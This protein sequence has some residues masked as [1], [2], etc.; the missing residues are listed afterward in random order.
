[1]PVE[2]PSEE[3]IYATGRVARFAGEMDFG[4]G[5]RGTHVGPTYRVSWNE[6]TH[7]LWAVSSPSGR[8]ILLGSIP[9][10]AEAE[11][12]L[13]GWQSWCGDRAPFGDENGLD[14]LV[15][16]LSGAGRLMPDD[17]VKGAVRY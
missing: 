1:M 6:G 17:P 15:D 9:T 5:W 10:L 4:G 3:A 2:F 14:W 12:L 8:L 13:D 7:E 11:K 16:R